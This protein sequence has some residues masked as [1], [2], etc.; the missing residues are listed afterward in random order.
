MATSGISTGPSID[1]AEKDKLFYFVTTIVV[2]RESDQKCLI[3]K[4]DKN[5][6]VYPG[7]WALP[8]GRLAWSDINLSK[9]DSVEGDVENFN[10][11]LENHVE[12]IV[13][14]K[15]GIEID[16]RPRYLESVFFIRGDG[17]PSVL[18]RFAVT[19]QSGEVEP[20]E[21]FTHHAW[22]GEEEVGDYDCI[23]GIDRDIVR[24]I[25]LFS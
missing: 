14:E 24:T 9:P 4:R 6:D 23:S 22:V 19:Y 16:N 7:K 10:R 5:D 8:G 20:R 21:E 25:K 2:F 15:A 12:S 18:V 1:K 3:L 11:P 17:T 13:K